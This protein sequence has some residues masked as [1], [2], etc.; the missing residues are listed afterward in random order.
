MKIT[1][2]DFYA[3]TKTTWLHKV[4]PPVKLLACFTIVVSAI[5]TNKIGILGSIFAL[6]IINL[7]FS[8]L[9][10]KKISALSLYPLLFLAVYFFS[11]NGLSIHFALSYL[12]KVLSISTAF[13][14][15]VFTTTYIE[16][17][18]T[19]S[20]FM[21]TVLLNSLFLTYRSIFILWST[22]ENITMAMHFRG[23]LKLNRPL[24][25]I[26]ILGNALGYLIIKAIESNEKIYNSM[27]MRGFSND[28]K[29]LRD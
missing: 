25:T 20:I 2:I 29:F 11:T 22:L 3:N 13:V 23:T 8:K 7:L 10:V 9:P 18:R 5:F 12:F 26:Q 14:T 16:I 21:P 28:M 19:L 24:Y 17:F 4:P 1:D 15:L 27:R 6:V